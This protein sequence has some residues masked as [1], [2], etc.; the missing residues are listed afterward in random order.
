MQFDAGE[1]FAD[2]LLDY[3]H[4]RHRE[5]PPFFL[6]AGIWF[7]PG[8]RDPAP[9][10]LLDELV[11]QVN[12]PFAGRD[13][14]DYVP[15]SADAG[16]APPLIV[17]KIG[18][19]WEQVWE[20]L[21]PFLKEAVVMPVA[22]PRPLVRVGSVLLDP[23][24]GTRGT[25]GVPVTRQQA[26]G[27][28]VPGFLTAGHTVA[29]VG[30]RLVQSRA[31]LSLRRAPLG[32]VALHRDPQVPPGV[33]A[34]SD[35]DIAVVD[36]E[37]SQPPLAPKSSGFAQLPPDPPQPIP[38]RMHGGFT[39]KSLATICASVRLVRSANRQWKD[40]WVMVPGIASQGDSGA[41]V[42]STPSQE[43][44][45]MLVGGSRQ[46]NSLRYALHYVQDHDSLQREVLTPAGVALL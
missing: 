28:A 5:L 46:G 6:G 29:G 24:L 7:G 44:I 22:K 12:E 43:L 17:G 18:G 35:F 8:V 40:C 41:A 26:E 32:Q 31:H 45:G 25:V 36:L 30:A 39:H 2:S 37:P 10:L 42:I 13:W 14:Q 38:V 34:S 20:E 4:D 16:G 27:G 3:L 9:L 1:A 23:S 11:T 15:G 33:P 19:A 21:G